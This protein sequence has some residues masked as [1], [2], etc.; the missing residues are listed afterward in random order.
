VNNDIDG[1]LVSDKEE[2]TEAT[3]MWDPTEDNL[4]SR[5]MEMVTAAPMLLDNE[6][7]ISHKL[8]IVHEL[9]LYAQSPS[10]RLCG[11]HRECLNPPGWWEQMKAWN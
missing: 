5:R 10:M 8:Q 1:T 4:V 9:E 2:P 11:N 3:L 6:A 7:K